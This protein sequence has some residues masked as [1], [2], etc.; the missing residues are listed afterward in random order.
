[1][2]EWKK[3]CCATD[4]GEPS[5]VALEAAA[6][7][8]RRF[9]AELTLVHVTVPPPPAASDVLV[10][11]RGVLRLEADEQEELLARWKLEAE[12]RA[13][14]P[15]TARALSGDPVGEIVRHVR[16]E[17]CD[18]VVVGTHGGGRLSRALL[19]SVADAVARRAPCPVLFVHDHGV[20]E[21]VDLAEEAGAYV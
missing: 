11:S 20:R 10:S 5:R 15:V 13:G 7:L 14:R 4:F 21:K 18:L 16:E 3:I 1:M 2:I 19:G 9:D 6:D 12:A 17:G 8:A